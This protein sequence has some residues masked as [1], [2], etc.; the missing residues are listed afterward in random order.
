VDDITLKGSRR[1]FILPALVGAILVGYN[2]WNWSQGRIA[3]STKVL[4][5]VPALLLLLKGVLLLSPMHLRL[6]GGRL[7]VC[8]NFGLNLSTP[9]RNVA[10]L[11]F[12]DGKAFLRFHD[13][14]Q[15]EG[16]KNLRSML[17][18]NLSRRGFHFEMPVVNEA[19]RQQR[20]Q[21]A[22]VRAAA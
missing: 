20:L 4:T 14:A 8:L 12:A 16:S 7:Q 1:G 17:E 9:T 19:E 18:Q 21:E 10:S 2:G 11:D 3:P 22:V 13:L 6:S 15:V 5:I